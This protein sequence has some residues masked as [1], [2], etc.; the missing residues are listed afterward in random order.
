MTRIS[1]WGSPEISAFL[2]GQIIENKAIEVE[3]VVT[4]EDKP[5]SYRGRQDEPTAVKKKADQFNIPVFTPKTLKNT[6]KENA[7]D[8]YKEISQFEIDVNVVFAYGKIIPERFFSLPKFG[9]LNFHASLLPLLRGASPI[10]HALLS[11]HEKTGWSMQKMVEKL[12]AGDIYYTHE[13]EIKWEDDFSSLADRLMTELLSFA[14]DVI[15]QYVGGKLSPLQQIEENSTHCGKIDPNRGQVNWFAPAFQV[16]NL[17]R[18]MSVRGGIFS[19]YNGK[20]C[21]LFPDL[22]VDKETILKSFDFSLQPGVISKVT[23]DHIWVSC[24]DAKS[25]PIKH[26]QPDGKK[27]LSAGEFVNGYRVKTGDRFDA[28]TG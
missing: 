2:L 17:A 25:L 28:F 7:D 10:E 24:D 1:F 15:L 26:V 22:L 27:R 6:L 12:D 19:S 14:P 9:S 4:Q 13:V 5:R 3:F 20:K 11:G 23:G 16:R 8:L 21:K 18:A